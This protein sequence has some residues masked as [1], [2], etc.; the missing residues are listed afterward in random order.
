MELAFTQSVNAQKPKAKVVTVTSG[1][2]GV[3]KTSTSTNLAL[4]LSAMNKKVC[5][6]DADTSLAN[7]NILLGVQPQYHLQHL[8]DGERSLEEVLY[9]GPRDLY[10]VPGASGITDY[11]QLNVDQKKRLLKA[12]DQL[13]SRFDYLIIDTAAGVGDEV[14]EFVNA[15]QYSVIVITPEPTSL[16]D[17]FS[18]LKVLKKH[19]YE[20]E[21]FVVVNMSLDEQSSQSIY[22]RFAS[23]VDKYIGIS[24][25]FLGFIQVDEAMISAV[26]LQC[27][28]VLLHPDAKASMCFSNIAQQIEK[29][30]GNKSV[31]SFSA[32]WRKRE[33]IE[34]AQDNPIEIKLPFLKK[35]NEEVATEDDEP[36]KPDPEDAV[37]PEAVA[38]DIKNDLTSLYHLIEQ[39][40]FSESVLKE[41]MNALRAVYLERYQS[42][43]E[44]AQTQRFKLLSNPRLTED[45]LL[46]FKSELEK[47][48]EK[49][50]NK[51]MIASNESISDTV[52]DQTLT[53]SEIDDQLQSAMDAYQLRFQQSYSKELE[54]R[55]KKSVEKANS[56]QFDKESLDAQ[57]A[58][59][60]SVI[61]RQKAVLE[62][63]QSLIK[64]S[65]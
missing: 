65:D 41:A 27:P 32:F 9:Q 51:K 61:D 45:D 42:D 38:D 35:E 49:R 44:S 53:Q 36:K 7:I 23:A 56:L 14:I 37:V 8:L 62:Q 30:C 47:C 29:T 39:A 31:Q 55:L 10:V 33:D 1:K 25:K 5:I 43:I 24:L 2:G 40:D 26:S 20:R 52:L 3:G 11:N 34:T 63:V 50:F 46:Q 15:S 16:T 6:F 48:Y 58:T 57:V 60:Q 21:V 28:T 64:S 4:S 19:Q 17:S 59:L 22:K 54:E 18:L 12:L 13:Q